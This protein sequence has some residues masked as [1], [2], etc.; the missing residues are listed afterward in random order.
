[1]IISI[2]PMKIYT[3]LMMTVAGLL[4]SCSKFESEVSIGQYRITYK[5]AT[6]SGTWY[7][8]YL[9]L[10]EEFCFCEKPYQPGDW[11]YTFTSNSIP[12]KLSISATSELF[13]DISVLDKPDVTVSIY[14]NGE[15]I[16]IETNS[17]A[18]G[19][20]AVSYPSAGSPQ[21]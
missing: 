5:V 20:S 21:L 8:T 4:C 17:E 11:T 15:L 9:G 16:A 7:G 2:K 19:K 18:D 13:E 6:E 14:I 3:I 10:T 1:M 12:E